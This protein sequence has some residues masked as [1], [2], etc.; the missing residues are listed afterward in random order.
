MRANR[1]RWSAVVLAVTLV[2]ADKD[3]KARRIPN[4][5][6]LPAFVLGLCAHALT[7]I[8][9]L[10]G[11]LQHA[12]DAGITS[13]REMIVAPAKLVFGLIVVSVQRLA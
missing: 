8:D 7:G 3:S 4:A 12:V 10:L 13:R 11:I 2:A 5:L 9:G 6:T 1:A